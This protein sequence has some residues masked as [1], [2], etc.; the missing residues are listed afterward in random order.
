L[1]K[2][3]STEI[4][5]IFIIAIDFAIAFVKRSNINRFIAV[6]RRFK[7][8]SLRQSPDFIQKR[9]KIRTFYF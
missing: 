1:I 7:S 2:T 5:T 6:D 8:L 9:G 3:Q 4:F